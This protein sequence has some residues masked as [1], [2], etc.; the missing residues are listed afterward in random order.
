MLVRVPSLRLLTA[1]LASLEAVRACPYHDARDVH[2]HE[3]E[4]A[5]VARREVLDALERRATPRPKFGGVPWGVD[6]TG[7]TV[8]GKIALTFDDGPC[9]FTDEIVDVLESNGVKGTFFLNGVNGDGGTASGKYDA[10][11]KRMFD[12]GHHLASHSWSHADFETISYDAKL[13]EITKLEESFVKLF[14]VIPTYF[15]PP[16]TS[17][18]SECYRS[19]NEMVYHVTDYNLDTKDFE[20]GGAASKGIYSGAL[21]S[22]NSATN[23]F[24]VLAHDIQPFT[25]DGF[26]QWMIDQARA[27][28]YSFA[29]LGECL[30]DP[31][32][33]WYRDPTTGGPRGASP[34]P[35]TTTSAPPPPPTTTS[36]SSSAPPTTSTSTTSSS[37]A[38]TTT[39]SSASGSAST[40]GP[41]RVT[42][43]STTRPTTT[44]A[45]PA[46]VTKNA[47]NV[48][49]AAG[50][51]FLGAVLGAAAWLL[52]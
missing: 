16:Y 3:S 39:S 43:S 31:P 9:D 38:P 25:R 49:G 4:E 6:I 7:C 26:V 45:P 44:T 51:T 17:C 35:P 2:D 50:N 15:R 23:S 20:N 48:V 18:G 28:G 27:K 19:L 34:P 24:I 29:T 46:V 21:N 14:G 10:L 12:S 52:V 13:A 32:A 30:G 37:A 47:A 41:A 42:T 22:A 36:T 8:P 33:N 5:V 1:L 40:S 11:L